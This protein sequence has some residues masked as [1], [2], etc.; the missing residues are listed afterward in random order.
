MDQDR[1]CVDYRK[2]NKVTVADSEPMTTVEDLFH[3]L[4]KSKYFSKI[5]L[6]KGYWQI[7]VAEKDIEKTAIVTPDGTY[8]FLR[9]AFGIKN[10]GGNIGSRNEE[11]FGRNK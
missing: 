1:T 7:P 5:D 6:S 2:L 9:V 8:D 4:K 10:S 3:R 11:E